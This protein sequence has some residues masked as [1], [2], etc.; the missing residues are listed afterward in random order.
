MALSLVLKSL[1]KNGE[2]PLSGNNEKMRPASNTI[3][4]EENRGGGEWMEVD[5]D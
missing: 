4:E 1:I 5:A 2:V 3:E